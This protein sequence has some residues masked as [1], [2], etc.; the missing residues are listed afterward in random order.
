M[1][2]RDRGDINSQCDNHTIE[3]HIEKILSK[4]YQGRD[5]GNINSQYGDHTIEVANKI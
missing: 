4:E 3:V 1:E 5:H 2:R